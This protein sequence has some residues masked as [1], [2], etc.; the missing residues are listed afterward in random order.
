VSENSIII[1]II[2]N[3]G[4][5]KSHQSWKTVWLRLNG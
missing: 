5:E 3:F 4:I 1:E 2:F